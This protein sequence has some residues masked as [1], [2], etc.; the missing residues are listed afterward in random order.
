MTLSR[1]LNRN[2]ELNPMK[3]VIILIVLLAITTG[4]SAQL[5]LATNG[6]VGIGTNNPTVKLQVEL[7]GIAW[8]RAIWARVT[9]PQGC[10]YNLWSIPKNK[11]VFYVCAEGWL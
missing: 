5:K 7:D 2:L 4:A 1:N 11:D 8:E 3:K 6:K 9:H 10:S